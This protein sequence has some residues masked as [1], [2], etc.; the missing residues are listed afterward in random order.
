MT[1]RVGLEDNL[2]C[3]VKHISTGEKLQLIANATIGFSYE[4]NNNPFIL[5]NSKNMEFVDFRCISV[6]TI[7]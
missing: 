7:P 2:M 1:D 5:D 6:L 3:R 4:F